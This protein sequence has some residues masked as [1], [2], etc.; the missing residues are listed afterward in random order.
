MLGSYSTSFSRF[1][2]FFIGFFFLF[3]KSYLSL[4]LASLSL[5][6]S[7]TFYRLSTGKSF[8][9]VPYI[10][11]LIAG[12]CLKL[13]NLPNKFISKLR[14]YSINYFALAVSW[15]F[16]KAVPLEML[17]SLFIT[18]L[19][20]FIFP[21]FLKKWW[22]SS[23][24]TEIGRFLMKISDSRSFFWSRSDFYFFSSCLIY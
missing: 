22:R 10:S 11:R 9:I 23:S 13:G 18:I 4:S 21:Y 6:F 24:F 12:F 15:N 1:L 7:A 17:H 20:N 14:L 2:I 8:N 3:F 16:T 5:I 19:A